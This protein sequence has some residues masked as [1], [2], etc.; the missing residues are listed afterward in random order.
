[1]KAIEVYV[2]NDPREHEDRVW[3]RRIA[4][5][6]LFLAGIACG[7]AWQILQTVE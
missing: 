1:M 4:Y 5:M 3:L 6:A 7:Y 2:R